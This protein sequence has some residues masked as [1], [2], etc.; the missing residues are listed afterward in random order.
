MGW[1]QLPQPCLA[2]LVGRGRRAEAR[3]GD[4]TICLSGTRRLRV[5]EEVAPGA[6]GKGY[7]RVLLEA[8]AAA[9]RA[10]GYGRIILYTH[11]KMVE[12]IALYTRFGYRETHRISEKGFDRV[13]MEKPL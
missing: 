3:E 5:R 9:A 10:A 12:N 8:A 7:G 4:V 6:Q 13:Y 1:T 2:C 11:E